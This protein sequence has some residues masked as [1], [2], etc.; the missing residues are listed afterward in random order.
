VVKDAQSFLQRKHD[1]IGTFF[2]KSKDHGVAASV[3]VRGPTTF[4]LDGIARAP[5]F[6]G[7][8]TF[9]AP[10]SFDILDVDEALSTL[11]R[12][13]LCCSIN[14]SSCLGSSASVR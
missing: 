10:D 1:V 4:P 5:A 8:R 13:S 3:N 14:R 11:G 6:E 9:R 7:D 2:K 12:S